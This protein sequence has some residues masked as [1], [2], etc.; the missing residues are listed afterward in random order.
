M[1]RLTSALAALLLLTGPTLAQDT[2]S[3]APEAETGAAETENTETETATEEA[4]A[5]ASAD[6]TAETVIAT[7]NGTEITLGEMIVL[8]AQLGEQYNQLPPEVLFEGLR[9]QLVQQQ[10]LADTLSEVP[11]RVDYTLANEE[12]SLKSGEIIS[13]LV[14]TAVTDEAV[15]EAYDAM[16][17]GE[18][19]TQE[20]NASHI[21]VETE[22]EALALIEELENG[23]DFGMLARQN[24][25]GPS[26]PN[27]GQLGWFGP[28]SMVPAFEEA[29]LALEVG[30]ISEP[31]QTEFGWHVITL[32]EVRDEERP[33]LEAVRPQIV[34]QLQEQAILARIEELT[35][36]AEIDQLGVGD[37]DPSVLTNLDLLEN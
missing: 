32:N 28:G 18:E 25:T 1:M 31:V 3:D 37:I 2:A 7:V 9:D 6:V 19:L 12:R 27:G 11:A 22:E 23:A 20:F 15:Q 21:L 26:G 10:L 30:E 29:V 5:P 4:D 13:D 14:A 36:T 35:E 16:F 17:E 24:S 8:R 33:P 34:A